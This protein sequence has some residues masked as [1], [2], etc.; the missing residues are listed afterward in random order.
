MSGVYQIKNKVNGK[1]Y[2]G[3]A[4]NIADRW[5]HHRSEL[6]MN[7]HI[8]KHLQSSWNKYGED[9]FEF[10]VLEYCVISDLI[11]FEQIWINKFE[12]EKLYNICE[13]AGSTL[14]R[15]LTEEHK[16]KL[17]QINLG[18]RH[19]EETKIKMSLNSARPA[20]GRR[21]GTSETSLWKYKKEDGLIPDIKGKRQVRLC[22]CGLLVQELYNEQGSFKGYKKT[23]GSKECIGRG[24]ARKGKPGTRLGVQL[25]AET[26]QKMSETAKRKNIPE[27]FTRKGCI[28]SESTRKSIS[29]ANQ[30][31]WSLTNPE[32]IVTQI[33]NLKQFCA[34]NDLNYNCMKGLTSNKQKQH[35]GWTKA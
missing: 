22:K 2:I 21:T 31:M 15:R 1:R 24:I 33:I 35:K 32:G 10:L 25:S 7:V 17:R 12:F 20:K 8:N 27:L 9:S 23:C 18:K 13:I 28:N 6:K 34:D 30:K 26:K 3:S 4:V 16:E 19:S 5:S 14:G 11:A 29:L